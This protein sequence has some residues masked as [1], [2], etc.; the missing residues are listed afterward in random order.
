MAKALLPR[1]GVSINP[2]PE[3]GSEG[4][5]DSDPTPPVCF[6]TDK[7]YFCTKRCR[8]AKECRKLIAEWLR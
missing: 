4:V 7:R 6:R 5:A 8:W 2:P 3:E 1:R